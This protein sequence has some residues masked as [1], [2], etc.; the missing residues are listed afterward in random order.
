MYLYDDADPVPGPT[1][2]KTPDDYEYSGC[3]IDDGLNRVHSGAFFKEIPTMTPE[4]CNERCKGSPFFATEFGNECFCGMPGDDYAALGEGI[5]NFD[6]AGDETQV[7]GG[8]DAMSVYVMKEYEPDTYSFLGCY[9]DDMVRVMSGTFK[10][11]DPMMTLMSCAIFCED[12]STYFGLEN[13]D[14]CWCGDATDIP[15]VYGEATCDDPC[16]G[17]DSERCGGH[18]ALSVYQFDDAPVDPRPT[19]IVVPESRPRKVAATY[20][21]CWSDT[22]DDR[23]MEE[24]LVTDELTL[25]VSKMSFNRATVSCGESRW[26]SHK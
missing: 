11:K 3:Y 21:G 7:C 10:M 5:C 14:E 24:E 6:C 15:D 2:V 23:M 16:S 9:R 8:R 4:D 17:D 12:S 25:E 13:A 22:F 19:P 26:I 18:W 1:P 20:M